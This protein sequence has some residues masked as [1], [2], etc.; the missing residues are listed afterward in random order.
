MDVKQG[1]VDSIG[2]TPLIRLKAASEATGCE[3]LG[4]AEFLNPGQSVKDRAALYII[5]DAVV[6]GAL[7]PG[8]TIVEGTAGNTGIGLALVGNALGFKSVIII[9]ETQSQE[10]KDMLRLCGAELIE[11]PA[12]PYK[13][14]NNYVK[15]SG[16]LADELAAKSPNGAIWANQ[17]DNV[18]NRQA[19]IETTGPEIWA[20]TGG[21]VDGFTCA[22]GTGGT[23]AGIAIALKERNKGVTVALADPMGAALYNFYK[24]GELKAEGTSI[25]EGIGQGRITANLEGAPID[26]AYQ[27]PD[28]EALPLIFDLLKHEGLCLG[29]SSGINV[30]GAIRLARQLG[31]GHTI[32]TILCDYGTRYQTKLFNPAFLRE[33]NLPAPDWL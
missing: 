21:K 23:L 27:I 17:F 10:K 20:Q 5:K 24:H 26:E 16:R 30:A 25:T 22:V 2:N 29:G 12:V 9:P 18:A 6:R 7:K 14:P 11:V 1:L 13:D 32:V 31:P 33:K 19:H 28:E 4:K 8:G 3:I 15:Y